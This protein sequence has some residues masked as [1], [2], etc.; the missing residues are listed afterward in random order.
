MSGE[1]PDAIGSNSD[2]DELFSLIKVANFT[3][4]SLQGRSW[5]NLSEN[6][7]KF[8]LKMLTSDPNKRA[9][10]EELLKDPWLKN[11]HDESLTSE[12]SNQYFNSMIKNIVIYQVIIVN[13]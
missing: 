5:R 7:K 3:I 4:P 12:K 8:L 1:Y 9:S 11:A 10:A 13:P 2:I 6:S